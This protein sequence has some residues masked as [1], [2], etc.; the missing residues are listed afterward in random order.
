[1]ESSNHLI[2]GSAGSRAPLKYGRLEYNDEAFH[3]V[4]HGP[5]YQGL[6]GLGANVHEEPESAGGPVSI[7]ESLVF[8]CE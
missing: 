5:L 2:P 7:S 3:V 4:G 6:H 1:M 8:A